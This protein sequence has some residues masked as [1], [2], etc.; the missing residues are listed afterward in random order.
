[1]AKKIYKDG[2]YT[3]EEHLTE[4]EHQE[5]KLA[6]EEQNV[7]EWKM[8]GKYTNKYGCGCVTILFGIPAIIMPIAIFQGEENIIGPWFM[9]LII[10]LICFYL[11]RTRKKDS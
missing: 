7:A 8:F 11:Y 5:R 9:M 4:Q 1:M 6:R 10:F 3:G 2:Q